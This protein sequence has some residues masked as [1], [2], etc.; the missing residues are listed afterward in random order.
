MNH[1]QDLT[2]PRSSAS[3]TAVQRLLKGRTSIIIAHRL[4]TVQQVDEIMVL[5]DGEIQE[6]G[7]RNQLVQDPDS[8]FSQLLKTGLEET[9][10]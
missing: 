5:A 3:T 6:H 7:E 9:I 8:V 1:L 10:Q 4:G 2:R